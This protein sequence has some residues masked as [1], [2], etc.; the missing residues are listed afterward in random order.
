V[1]GMHPSGV[2]KLREPVFPQRADLTRREEATPVAAQEPPVEQTPAGP[3]P[4]PPPA[5]SCTSRHVIVVVEVILPT[6]APGSVGGKGDEAG[7][8]QVPAGRQASPA[9]HKA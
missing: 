8:D 7:R 3:P 9:P 6:A 2:A 4:A 5:R 1:P